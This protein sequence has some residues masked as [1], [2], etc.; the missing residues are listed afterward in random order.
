L[1]EIEQQPEEMLVTAAFSWD[2]LWGNGPIRMF[3][4]YASPYPEAFY[5]C[6]YIAIDTQEFD[7]EAWAFVGGIT[8][9]YVEDCAGKQWIDVTEQVA[10][11]L[12]ALSYG[13]PPA[14]AVPTMV[15]GAC[16]YADG[17]C[18]PGTPQLCQEP[19]VFYP[20]VTC[21]ELLSVCNPLP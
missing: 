17:T 8:R 5:P 15:C 7:P 10:G 6:R 18:L 20:D 12:S 19:N 21:D 11:D 9:I 16:C 13:S 4:G 1:F 2:P 14:P 3:G